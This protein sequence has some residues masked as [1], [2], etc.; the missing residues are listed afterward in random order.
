MP[1]VIGLKAKPSLRNLPAGITQLR[2]QRAGKPGYILS[3]VSVQLVLGDSKCVG[4]L[5]GFP[6][7]GLLK[8]R[9]CGSQND[10]HQVLPKV[11][12]VFR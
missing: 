7:I 11:K 12:G 6:G 3:D 10:I 5:P 9:H 1:L 4:S 2:I 8:G